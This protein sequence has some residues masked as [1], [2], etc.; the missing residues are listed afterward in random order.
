MAFKEIE[1]NRKP[2][3]LH[4]ARISPDFTHKTIIVEDYWDYV[5]LWL[6]RRSETDAIVFWKQA[7]YFFKA[8]RAMPNQA[9][10]LTL[11]YAFLNAA[12]ALLKVKKVAFSENHGTSGEL[13]LG[14]T[15][16]KNEIVTFKNSGV[17]SSLCAY[18]RQPTSNNKYSL[19]DILYNLA[20]VHRSFQL[21]FP[22]G[23]PDLF[24]PILNPRFVLKDSSTEAWFCAN[25]T[26][27][28]ANGFTLNKIAKNRFERDIG[29]A[30]NFVIRK[31]DRFAWHT[32]GAQK[33]TNLKRLGDYHAT[34]R[35]NVHYIVGPNT[36]WYIK[37]KDLKNGIIEREP[38][39][40]IYAA[41]HRL[42]ELA[43]YDPIKLRR[44]FDL[45]QNW[46]LSEFIR[47]APLEFIDNLACEMTNH[48]FMF[49]GLRRTR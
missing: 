10:P 12:K 20:F 40:L 49:R 22:S 1:Y 19:K 29:I 3:Y 5:E 15:N 7:K 6:R 44:H 43:R 33:S 24:V 28:Y 27:Q 18:F 26:G 14:N 21:T 45:D 39:T 42:S 36:L 34:L 37:R 35:Q 41:M 11:Y 48:D 17:L 32:S 25:L 38:L 2:L 46:L 9:A 47:C 4:K 13:A 23:Y 30:D 8:S 16:L 31:K